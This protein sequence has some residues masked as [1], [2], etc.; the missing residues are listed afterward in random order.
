[1]IFIAIFLNLL[2]VLLTYD[3]TPLENYVYK[4]IHEGTFT[5]C[6]IA[7]A[8]NASIIYEK[9]FGTQSSN[10]GLYSFPVIN[11]TLFDIGFLTQVIATNSALMDLID[12]KKL[13]SNHRIG[14]YLP[15]FDEV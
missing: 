14:A 3:W 15:A 1:M 12:I 10:L 2:T 5:G 8:T 6:S 4:A 11:S 7:I 9:P 13:H